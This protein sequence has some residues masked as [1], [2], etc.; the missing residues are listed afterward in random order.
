LNSSR[1]I[2]L[3]WVHAQRLEHPPPH[4]LAYIQAETFFQDKLQE[5]DALSGIGV[6]GPW[7]EM[8]SQFSI[9]LEEAEI[10]ESGRVVEQ[11]A[12]R[13]LPLRMKWD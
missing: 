4:L 11:Q 9:G 13:Q 8:E 12:Q 2:K 3:V 10:G 7:I 1:Q 5:D 6:A